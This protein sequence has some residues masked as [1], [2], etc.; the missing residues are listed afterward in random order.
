MSIKPYLTFKL[1]D[2]DHE[3]T[4]PVTGSEPLAHASSSSQLCITLL[5]GYTRNLRVLGPIFIP[6]CLVTFRIINLTQYFVHEA[7]LFAPPVDLIFPSV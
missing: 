5:G 2:G 3:F 6:F 7:D 1:P 4:P